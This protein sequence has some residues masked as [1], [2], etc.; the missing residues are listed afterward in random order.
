MRFPNRPR[1]APKSSIQAQIDPGSVRVATLNHAACAL[2]PLL[3]QMDHR[4]GRDDR[5]DQVQH[6]NRH[7]DGDDDADDDDK[8]KKK[9]RGKR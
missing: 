6:R 1:Q 3:N 9:V 5:H 7:Q 4:G 2:A 8:P